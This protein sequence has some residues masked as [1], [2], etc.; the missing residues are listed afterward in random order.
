MKKII[1]LLCLVSI[2]ILTYGQYSQYQIGDTIKP[3]Y[4]Y[5]FPLLGAKAYEKGFDIPYPIGIM[6]NYFY[7]AQD[8]LITDIAIGFSDG[9]L[10]NIPLT[11]ITRI[12]EFEEIKA[13]VHSINVRP[14]LWVF[15]FL[16][17]YG[18]LGKSYANTE[19]KL[20]YPI[21][22]KAL[23]EL[24]GS[25]F[26]IG[27]TGAFG[28]GKYFVVLDGNWVWSNMSNF[29]DP[30]KSST[31]SQRLGRAFPIGKNP[32]SNVAFW[33]GGMRIRMGGITEGSI[34]LRDVLPA[35]TWDRR[36]EIVNE[37]YTWYDSADPL[38]QQMADRV[39]TPIVD[40]IGAS[41]GDGTI[42]Y[43][44]TKEPKQEWNVIVGGQYQINKRWQIRSEG[45]I[46]GNRT[47]FLLS[48]NYRFGI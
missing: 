43:K 30:V 37:Y 35:E 32:E 19:V 2:S 18:I 9:L 44:L 48:V 28:L 22:L 46:L 39:L 36:D 3:A 41:N 23:A 26:G 7:G 42:S 5:K 15:P 1:F 40:N 38:A 47:S 11:D 8:I 29:E 10:P 24:E 25:S 14:D 27:M 17:V 34:T 45:G 16:N 31:F 21:E 33:V 6:L 13:N 20:S 12:I 4:P